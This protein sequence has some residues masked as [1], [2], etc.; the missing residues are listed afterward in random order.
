MNRWTIT[1]FGG[2]LLFAVAAQAIGQ[3][4]GG[5]E[6][7]QDAP[8]SFDHGLP[9]GPRRPRVATTFARSTFGDSYP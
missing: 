5:R 4:N 8:P 2:A 7:G 9:Y 3:Q 6:R 1:M